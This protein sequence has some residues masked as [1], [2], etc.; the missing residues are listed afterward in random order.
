VRTDD[1]VWHARI[2]TYMAGTEAERE[3][4]GRC[5][6]GD[7]D[8]RHQIALM[9][10]ELSRGTD[11][12]KRELRLRA[13]TRMLVRRHRARIER[14]AKALLARTTLSAGRLDKLVGRSVN[15]VNAA[16]TL[17]G[18]AEAA[19][20]RDQVELASQLGKM[21]RASA[22]WLEII[23]LRPPAVGKSTMDVPF[24]ARPLWRSAQ[25]GRQ[26]RRPVPHQARPRCLGRAC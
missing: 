12:S 21:R 25:S 14:V 26:P 4:L 23:L 11:W 15:D 9:A 13:M 10:E 7:G 2:I 17:H 24:P 18:A 22:R 20:D 5:R 1:A 6:G 8:D 3:I 19:W 16:P